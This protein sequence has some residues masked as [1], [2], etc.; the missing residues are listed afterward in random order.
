VRV[1]KTNIVS[2]R[3]FLVRRAESR[4]R[5]LVSLLLERG[6]HVGSLRKS[7]V[8]GL[9]ISG[10]DRGVHLIIERGGAAYDQHSA[11]I[12]HGRGVKDARRYH[13]ICCPRN[14]AGRG[15]LVSFE[16]LG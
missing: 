1:Q 8:A 9:K 7:S 15:V 10:D 14:S 5:L 11:V 2:L 12:D 4:F 3:G 16:S 6:S 13:I